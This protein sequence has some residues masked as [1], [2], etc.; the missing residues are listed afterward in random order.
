MSLTL[1]PDLASLFLFLGEEFCFVKLYLVLYY[2]TLVCWRP[3]VFWSWNRGQWI[4][5]KLVGNRGIEKC[6][7]HVLYEKKRSTFL[8]III[9]IKSSK[10]FFFSIGYCLYLHFKCYPLS[11]FPPSHILSPPASKRVFLHSPTHSH[12]PAWDSPILGLLSN[13]HRTKDIIKDS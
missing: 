9:I 7:R 3:A 12:L 5:V 11:R 1:L 4:W 8:V 6:G 10:I 13:L 2:V